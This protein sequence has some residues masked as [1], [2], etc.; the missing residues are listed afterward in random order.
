MRFM[1]IVKHV[2][3]SQGP[4]PKELIDAINKAVEEAQKTGTLLGNG[5]LLPTAQGARVRLANGHVSVT[6]GPFA[7]TKEVIGGYAQF[8]LESKQEAVEAAVKFMELHKKHWPGWEGETEIRQMFDAQ[9]CASAPKS[10][11]EKQELVKQSA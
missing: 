8:E 1:M 6:D 4:P 5:G 9:D 2:G 11:T 7:E 10:V 3:E